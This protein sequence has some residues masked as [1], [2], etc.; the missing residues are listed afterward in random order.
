MVDVTVRFV[1]GNPGKVSEVEERL[2][3]PV[4]QIDFDYVEIQADELESIALAGVRDAYEAVGD[5]TPIVVEDSGLFVDTLEGFPGPYSAFVEDTLGI[6]RVWDLVEDAND[7]SAHFESVVA[8]FDGEI[9]ETFIGTVEGEIVAPRGDGGFGYDP[10]FEVDG[11]TLAERST[12][13]K[14]E[15]SHRGRAFDRFAAWYD[16][17]T[18]GSPSGPG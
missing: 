5:G 18:A 2:D 8:Y 11:R 14:N 10:I 1:T 17:Q 9:E 6:E 7:R 12:T 13:E 3:E 16:D 4:E 15:L